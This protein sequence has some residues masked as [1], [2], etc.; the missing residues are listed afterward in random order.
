[1]N[2]KVNITCYTTP[3]MRSLEVGDYVLDDSSDL[4]I[5]SDNACFINLRTGETYEEDAVPTFKILERVAIK[6]EDE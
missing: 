4:M 1:M 3:P 5:Y 6:I 2:T